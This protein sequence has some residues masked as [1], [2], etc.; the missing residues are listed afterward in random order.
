MK[1][2]GTLVLICLAF[3]G[4]AQKT[5]DYGGVKGDSNFDCDQNAVGDS[6]SYD[7]GKVC[8]SKNELEIRLR[9]SYAPHSGTNTIVITYNE[10]NWVAK[11]F[12]I[13]FGGAVGAI[14]D[15]KRLFRNPYE[16]KGYDSVFM[17]LFERL[18]KNEIFLLPSQINLHPKGMVMDGV[19]YLL[20]Y[21]I[22]DKF[23]TYNFDNPQLYKKSN[24]DM[25]EFDEYQLI[26]NLIT[27]LFD[28]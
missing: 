19:V 18:K 15:S 12:E 28:K 17:S 24:P 20:T 13:K 5:L 23:R 27:Y 9:T 2:I 1:L 4:Y 16:P 14:V 22:G 11:K 6:I 8:N 7:I 25:K 21:K 26:V 3:C 10:G